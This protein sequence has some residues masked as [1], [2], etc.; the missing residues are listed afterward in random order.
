MSSLSLDALPDVLR[1]LRARPLLVINLDVQP[2]QMVGATPGTFRR[3]GVIPGGTFE[4]ERLSGEILPGGSDWQSVRSDG[5]VG[6]DVRMVL[7]T[8]DDALIGMTYRGIRQGPADVIARVNKGEVVDAASYYFRVAP[9]FETAA[10][11]YA[12]LNNIV[13]IGIG[14][15]LAVG[16][17]Y[18]VFEI[19]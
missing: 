5:G 18:S 16:A 4:G 19:L 12:W 7:K 14:H 11:Q 1:S 13:T 2:L 8:R 9:F 3:V 10:P 6:I 15:R 17:V